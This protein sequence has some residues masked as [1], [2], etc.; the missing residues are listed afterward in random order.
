MREGGGFGWKT[1]NRAAGARF[2]RPKCGGALI[3][4]EGTQFGWGKLGLKGWEV[5]ING[6]VRV[7]GFG[8]KTENEPP[9]LGF[10]ERNMGGLRFR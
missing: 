6:R 7:G 4:V 2:S 5:G 10:R 1:E 9:G 8:W 3:W